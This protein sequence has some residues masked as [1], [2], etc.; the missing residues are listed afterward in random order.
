MNNLA[1]Y[2]NLLESKNIKLWK[3]LNQYN[4]PSS[5]PNRHLPEILFIGASNA[6]K[7]TLINN[8]SGEKICKTSK[9]PGHTKKLNLISLNEQLLLIDSPG[10]GYKSNEEWGQLV[11]YCFDESTKLKQIYL[12]INSKR[13]L[14]YIDELMLENLKSY[15]IPIQLVLTK[16]DKCKEFK[17]RNSVSVSELVNGM[18]WRLIKNTCN[19]EAIVTSK[20]FKHGGIDLLKS[21]II[22]QID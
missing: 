9:K 6:G 11:N 22:D 4:L 19:K 14:N 21:N 18:N 16:G 13:K 3:S 20:D 5:W 10:Y 8:L 2:K 12:L 17:D 1:R 15:K 7:S